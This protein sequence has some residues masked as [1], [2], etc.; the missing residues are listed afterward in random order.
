MALWR[1]FKQPSTG[2]EEIQWRFVSN[3]ASRSGLAKAPQGERRIK[4]TGTVIEV[5]LERWC[6]GALDGSRFA[7]FWDVLR[8]DDNLLDWVSKGKKA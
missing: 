4:C 6:Y 1:E 8:V 7:A 3:N 5:P 2:R